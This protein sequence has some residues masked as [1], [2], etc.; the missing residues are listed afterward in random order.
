MV[1]CSLRLA[2]FFLTLLLEFVLNALFYNLYP[3]EDEDTPL[4]WDGII[5]NFWVSFYSFLFAMTPLLLLG[6][7]FTASRKMKE[8]LKLATDALALKEKYRNNMKNKIR[9]KTVGG[10]VFFAIL[11]N[12][13]LLYIVCFCHVASKRMSEDW[14]RSSGILVVLDLLILELLP[15]MLFG[16]LGLFYRLCNRSNLMICVIVLMESYR[17]YRNLVEV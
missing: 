13:L 14:L 1:P 2:F 5:E 6:C 4:F 7:V 3:P 12:Y 15:G 16:L 11:S 9:C 8:Q 17:F 10:L